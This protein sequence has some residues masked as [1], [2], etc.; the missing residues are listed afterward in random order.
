MFAAVGLLLSTQG[1]IKDPAPVFGTGS[2]QLNGV[3]KRCDVQSNVTYPVVSNQPYDRLDIT[4]STTP[5]PATGP[6]NVTLTFTKGRAQPT[7]TYQLTDM[8]Y[9]ATSGVSATYPL[10]TVH[11]QEAKGN[12]AGTF[13]GTSST[14][15]TPS[16]FEITDGS[17]AGVRTG[18]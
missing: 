15:P 8:N 4:L 9:Q 18:E 12:Y 10:S 1:C 13:A 14:G 5:E 6:E 17:F 11:L 7:T 3:I 2:Y 16:L